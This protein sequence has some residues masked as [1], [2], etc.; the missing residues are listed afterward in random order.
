MLILAVYLIV[1]TV[2]K[3]FFF[4]KGVPVNIS[5]WGEGRGRLLDQGPLVIGQKVTFNTNV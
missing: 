2:W 4:P 1:E 3:F 5:C